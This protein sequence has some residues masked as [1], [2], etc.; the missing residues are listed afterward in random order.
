MKPHDPQLRKRDPEL[1]SYALRRFSNAAGLSVATHLLKGSLAMKTRL[2]GLKKSYDE[3]QAIEE[4]IKK[5]IKWRTGRP[6]RESK[7]PK[8]MKFQYEKNRMRIE[9]LRENTWRNRVKVQ[10]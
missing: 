9:K 2:E 8:V 1:V 6:V 7:N 5:L 4:R 10:R 3:R